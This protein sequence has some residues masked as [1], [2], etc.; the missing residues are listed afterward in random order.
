MTRRTTLL[1]FSAALLV[2]AAGALDAASIPEQDSRNVI[3]PDGETHFQMLV[4]TSREAWMARASDLRK[5]ILA[6]AGL[7]PVPARTPLHPQIFGKLE[8]EG[9]S[10]EKVLLETYPGF[11]L[12]GNLYRPL[13][14]TGPFPAVVSRTVTGN[15]DQAKSAPERYLTPEL[16]SWAGSPTARAQHQNS[17]STY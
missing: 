8:R 7:L 9:Y 16:I 6:S 17:G 11:C 2:C 4:F 15:M 12:G 14:K 13:G 5:Q 3:L 10:V 1:V